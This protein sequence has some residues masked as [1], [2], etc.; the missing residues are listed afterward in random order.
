MGFTP[1]TKERELA[2]VPRYDLDGKRHGNTLTDDMISIK[3]P[4]KVDNHLSESLMYINEPYYDD[5]Y[6]NYDG[7]SMYTPN[8][9]S[10]ASHISPIPMDN[11]L[12]SRKKFVTEGNGVYADHLSIFD[13]T[14]M[15]DLMAQYEKAMLDK[16]AQ[17]E[18]RNVSKGGSLSDDVRY[19]RSNGRTYHDKGDLMPRWDAEEDPALGS[20]VNYYALSPNT[21]EQLVKMGVNRPESEDMMGLLNLYKYYLDNLKSQQ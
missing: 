10:Q 17:A 21:M 7:E 16:K 11:N 4:R 15:E 12:V 5:S 6:L 14:P 20:T 9:L 13:G 8:L 18:L 2:N 3:N 1:H 19:I